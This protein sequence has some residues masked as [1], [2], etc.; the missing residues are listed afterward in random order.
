MEILYLAVCCTLYI[1]IIDESSC[2]DDAEKNYNIK[3]N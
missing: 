1:Y 3:N 2:L